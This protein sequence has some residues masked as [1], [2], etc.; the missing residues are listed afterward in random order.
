MTISSSTKFIRSAFIAVLVFLTMLCA[1]AFAASYPESSHPYANNANQTWTY[2]FP[3]E[4]SE[5]KITFSSDTEFEN[6]Y[7]KLIITGA[8]NSTQ[9]FTGTQLKNA[10]VT[11]SGNS[12]TLNLTSDN[13]VSKYGFRITDISP[14]GYPESLHPYA[15]NTDHTWTYAYPM[16]A[17]ALKVTFS[18][19]TELESNYDYVILTGI[20]GVQ[21]KYTG[22][23]LKGA[24]VT[25]PGNS[26]TLR[27]TTDSSTNK[28]GFK[29]TDIA[30]IV[31]NS[32]SF[33]QSEHPYA[34]N[35]DHSWTYTHPTDAASL[36]VT[37]SSETQ[38]ENAKDYLYITGSDGVERSYTGTMLKGATVTIPGNSFTIRLASDETI[39]EYGFRIV[40]IA[41]VAAS[42][43][44]EIG[45]CGSLSYE[46]DTASKTLTIF[47]NGPLASYGSA[48][49]APWYGWRYNIEHILIEEGVTTIGSL[50]FADLS[51]L[52]DVYFASTVTAISSTAFNNAPETVNASGVSGTCSWRLS[53]NTMT[54][55][56]SGAMADY[57]S[58]SYVP[59][60]WLHDRITSINI[61]SGVTHVGAYTFYDSG[62]TTCSLSLPE[63]LVSIGEGAF[64][65][66]LLKSLTL[67]STLKEIGDE[68]FAESVTSL[69]SI[70][71]P[72][73]LLTLGGAAFSAGSYARST[74]LT[75]VQI[76]AS[77][78][79]W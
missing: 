30:P 45:S 14:V 49:L 7:D 69:S 79:N 12:F 74:S 10:T 5:L 37:F 52:K 25:V 51:Y 13:S 57:A 22:T 64:E 59:W 28:Y 73:G 19:D 53:G 72:D 17:D 70:S 76:P 67:P 77:L 3:G 32:D 54:V 60:Y 56:G 16:E 18:A 78:V 46:L 58:F 8:D 48:S 44:I 40:N 6:S 55:S 38:F 35:T 43:R 50:C 27:L 68:A 65:S 34:N 2:S 9:T 20:D 4:T 31:A 71:L 61:A 15:I 24:E 66:I 39:T 1:E 23:Q 75:S 42:S 63:G 26:F 33:P 36:K 47:G 29:I 11:V 41:A 21:H 62:N